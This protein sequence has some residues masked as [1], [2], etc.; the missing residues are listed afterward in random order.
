M[1]V[2]D[3]SRSARFDSVGE[4]DTHGPDVSFPFFNKVDNGRTVK[5]SGTDVSSIGLV[6][7]ERAKNPNGSYS[8]ESFRSRPVEIE[9]DDKLSLRRFRNAIVS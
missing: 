2:E 3:G 6:G 4:A 7:E 5:G 9:K 8:F 1:P